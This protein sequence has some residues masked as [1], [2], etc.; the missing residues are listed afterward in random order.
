MLTCQSGEVETG[1]PHNDADREKHQGGKNAQVKDDG[2]D[3]SHEHP[4]EH[5]TWNIET[6]HG[7]S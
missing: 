7:P 4:R 5:E 2:E 1:W 6:L 3:H